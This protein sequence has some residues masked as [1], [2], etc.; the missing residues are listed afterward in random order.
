MLGC[1]SDD[2]QFEWFHYACAGLDPA[3]PVPKKIGSAQTV[4]RGLWESVSKKG[5]MQLLY[6]KR[7]GW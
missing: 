2:C 6:R 4:G 5:L 1:D 3:Q 7:P